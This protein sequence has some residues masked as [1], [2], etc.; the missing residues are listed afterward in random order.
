MNRAYIDASLEA[1]V[2]RDRLVVVT[3]LIAVIALAWAYLL[4]GAGMGTSA[5][6]MTRMSQLATAGGMAGMAI[7]TPAVWTPGYAVLM[8]FMWWIMMMAMML[9]S[10][11]PMILLF[12]RVNGKQRESGHPHVATSI[13]AVGYLAAWASFSLV[14]TILQWAFERSGLISPMLVGTNVFFGGVLLLAAGVYQLT[15]IKHA[16]LRQCRSPLAFLSAHWQRG[17]RGALRM[18]F[19][20]G[21]FC[22]GCCWFLMGLLFFGGVM[23]LYWIAGL[24]LFVLFEKTVPAGHWASYVTGAVL[25]VWGILILTLAS[26][27]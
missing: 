27:Q 19:V 18:G 15:P 17:A 8:F 23:N 5:F 7:M 12:A 3:A 6:E 25:L 11:A 22:V 26:G 20:H 14:A 24:A 1:V 10:A 13:F 2:R 9:P 21:V 16:C 4:A